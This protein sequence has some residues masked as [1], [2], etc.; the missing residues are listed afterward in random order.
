MNE[1]EEEYGDQYELPTFRRR[2]LSVQDAALR[3]R[4][5]ER[6][7][8]TVDAPTVA[9]HIQAVIRA[10]A[11]GSGPDSEIVLALSE[12]VGQA[13]DEEVLALEALDLEA[14]EHDLHAVSWML[15]QPPPERAIDARAL[16]KMGSQSQSLGFRKAQAM[17]PELRALEKLALDDHWMVIEKLCQN[18]RIR[19]SHIMTIVTRRPTIPELI[20]TVAKNNRWYRRPILREAIVQ[21]PYGETALSLRTLPTLR[22]RQWASIQHASQVHRAVRGFASYLVA[23]G[24]TDDAEP[25]PAL[26][27]ETTH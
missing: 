6:H 15:L 1:S 3:R 10:A 2:V 24:R 14:R 21:N 25:G 4:Q 7:V 8:L 22:P 18:P 26:L 27:V 16:A 20:A 13:E 12:F 19:E 5:I 17:K 23:L 9:R 11:R